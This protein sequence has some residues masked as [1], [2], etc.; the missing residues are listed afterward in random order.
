MNRQLQN[1]G[2]SSYNL[3]RFLASSKDKID[4]EDDSGQYEHLKKQYKRFY[5][6]EDLVSFNKTERLVYTF[7]ELEEKFKNIEILNEPFRSGEYLLIK[8]KPR[9]RSMYHFEELQL[10]GNKRK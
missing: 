2:A 3:D 6:K 1:S 10:R 8:I 9:E 4:N 5:D 7:M